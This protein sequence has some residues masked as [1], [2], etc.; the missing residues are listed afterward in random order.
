MPACARAC[1]TRVKYRG[2]VAPD[3]CVQPDHCA[4]AELVPT[5]GLTI[6]LRLDYSASS[7]GYRASEDREYWSVQPEATDGL[8]DLAAA[9]LTAP[10]RDG[11]NT[12]DFPDANTAVT[13]RHTGTSLHQDSRGVWQGL[14]VPAR[15][16][17]SRIS[18][19][20][21]KWANPATTAW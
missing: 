6:A 8:A 17:A 5:A 7:P 10:L 1:H 11:A 13:P 21:A 19:W 20:S 12:T 4:C 15:E 18:A 2:P 16:V 3:R 9:D 14:P